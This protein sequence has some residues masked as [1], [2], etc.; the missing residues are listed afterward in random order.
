V[1]VDLTVQHLLAEPGVVETAL[2]TVQLV[3]PVESILGVVAELVGIQQTVL[4]VLA[5]L[6]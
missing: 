1:A 3:E 5:D 2:L 6:V 4:V